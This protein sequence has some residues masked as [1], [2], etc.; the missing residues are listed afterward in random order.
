MKSGNML[1]IN[2]SLSQE[3]YN[4]RISKYGR[5]LE[6][7]YGKHLSI[8][9]ELEFINKLESK[10]KSINYIIKKLPRDYLSSMILCFYIQIY[11]LAHNWALVLD[12]CIQ[13]FK[14]PFESMQSAVTIL[15][16]MARTARELKNYKYLFIICKYALLRMDKGERFIIPDVLK[17]LLIALRELPGRYLLNINSLLV[18][19]FN[20]IRKKKLHRNVS[21]QDLEDLML[22]WEKWGKMFNYINNYGKELTRKE[23]KIMRDYIKL[24]PF[25][26]LVNGFNNN[27][28]K[29]D[30]FI[31]KY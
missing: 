3:Y 28:K 29:Q 15:I 22:N 2:I 25:S 26:I 7:A 13:R 24:C 17:E 11:Y 12:L 9:K 21:L 31:V 10:D 14:F 18:D 20:L 19:S 23:R 8:G 30:R 5:L 6:L 16:I 4:I 1:I 27:M